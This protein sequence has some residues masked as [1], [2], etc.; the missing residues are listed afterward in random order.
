MSEEIKNK[1]RGPVQWLMT[2][3]GVAVIGWGL[4][5]GVK[6]FIGD[7]TSETSDDAQVEQY[8]SPINAKVQGY[9]KEIRFTEHQFVHR[10]DTLLI[11]DD[12]EYR[13]RVA[14]A[15]AMIEQAD[16]GVGVQTATMN[17]INER[18]ETAAA[19]EGITQAGTEAAQ[20]SIA[21]AQA[22]VDETRA[23]ME[24]ARSEYQRYENLLARDAATPQQYERM[25]TALETAQSRYNSA[26]AALDAAKSRAAASKAQQSQSSSNTRATAAGRNEQ[27]QRIRQTQANSRAARA[28]RDLAA[29]NL[30]YTVITA[31][32]DGWVGRRSIQEG[33]LIMPGTTITSIIPNTPKW[34]IAN[35]REKQ[36]ENIG[37]GQEVE[38]TIDAMR[39]KS[40]KGHVTAIAGATGAKFSAVPT[41]NSAGNFVKI[42][43]RVPV[44]IDF[45]GLTQKDIEQ[46]AAGMMAVVRVRTKK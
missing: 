29:L 46:M 6:L 44:R 42:Q 10:G 34:V 19:G 43:Q 31:P 28:Q 30:S 2:I 35:F 15:D 4:W 1:K 11:I 3:V 32:C 39:G 13:L 25:K 17:T 23:A 26:L 12:S 20:A 9:I 7:A 40:Y 45:D 24:N 5:E 36:I 27:S 14:Q 21:Q 16:A 38:I 18:V 41:D 8:V 33:Q 37:V 22:H